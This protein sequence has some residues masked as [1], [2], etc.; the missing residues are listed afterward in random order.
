MLFRNFDKLFN[1]FF[2]SDPFFTNGDNWEKKSYKSDDGTISFTYITNKRGN[3]EK[4]DELS[5]LK[6]KMNL[7]VDEQNFEEAAKLRD[8]IKLLETNVDK[9]NELN[10][11]M[12]ECIKTQ[13]F[14]RAIEI[15]D[16]LNSLK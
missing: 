14:E 10:K 6:Q 15:R 3:L 2:N 4:P 8:K 7:A 13:N 9:I 1:E 5:L 11:E 12:S 16:E